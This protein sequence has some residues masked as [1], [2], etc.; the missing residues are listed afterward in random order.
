MAEMSNL[1]EE[2]MSTL[3]HLR[4]SDFYFESVHNEYAFIFFKQRKVPNVNK[5]FFVVVLSPSLPMHPKTFVWNNYISV[6]MRTKHAC[7]AFYTHHPKLAVP[8][9]TYM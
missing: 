3:L 7:F 4:Y 8:G 2:M 1:E 5:A 6:C 9:T